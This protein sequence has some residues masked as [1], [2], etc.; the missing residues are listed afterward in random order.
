MERKDFIAMVGQ[1]AS[2]L[3]I[4]CLAGC[5]KNQGISGTTAPSNID[6]TIDLSQAANA[7]LNNNGGFIYSNGVIVART[8]SGSFIAVQQICTHESY[9][10]VYQGNQHQFYCGGHGAT[11]SEDGTV[12]SGPPKRSLAKF[13]TTLNGNIL[14]VYA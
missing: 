4:S 7:Q 9:S 3:F 13:N 1:S 11:F 8:L 6:F 10:V 2:L 12:T 14:R 5:T